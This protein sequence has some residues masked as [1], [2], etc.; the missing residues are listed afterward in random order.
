MN[1]LSTYFDYLDH[2]Y[3]Y[4]STLLDNSEDPQIDA[5]GGDSLCLQVRLRLQGQVEL[6]IGSLLRPPHLRF[7]SDNQRCTAWDTNEIGVYD[8]RRDDLLGCDHT[9]NPIIEGPFH[10]HLN[11]ATREPVVCA[12]GYCILRRS[13]WDGGSRAGYLELYQEPRACWLWRYVHAWT[14]WILAPPNWSLSED[15]G[16][17][18]IRTRFAGYPE[19]LPC[20]TA[21]GVRF[22]T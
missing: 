6:R 2:M 10:L 17:W 4:L 22:V 9:W 12:E 3:V 1:L 11:L 13:W 15:A 8:Q 18:L 14:R 20:P 16:Q 19:I 21:S 5:L 7:A